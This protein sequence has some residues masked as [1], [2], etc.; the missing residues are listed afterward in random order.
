MPLTAWARQLMFQCSMDTASLTRAQS[1][2]PTRIQPSMQSHSPRS[3]SQNLMRSSKLTQK[4]RSTARGSQTLSSSSSTWYKNPSSITVGYST[5]TKLTKIHQ[6]SKKLNNLAIETF[7]KP[8]LKIK[9]SCFVFRNGRGRSE[10]NRGLSLEILLKTQW[11]GLT[12]IS[13]LDSR[14]VRRTLFSCRS[15]TD[16]LANP[17]KIKARASKQAMKQRAKV[18]SQ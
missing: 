10:S 17:S 8:W 1:A 6:P 11:Q 7:L 18:N 14:I 16:Q 2:S 15:S 9:M 4:E 12:P 3:S 13:R 5:K